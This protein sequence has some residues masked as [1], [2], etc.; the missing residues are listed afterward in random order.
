MGSAYP[1]A[2]LGPLPVV[3]SNQVVDDPSQTPS[4]VVLSNQC[5]SAMRY[6]PHYSDVALFPDLVFVW[7]D[8]HVDHGLQRIALNVL[9]DQ[10][11]V[12]MAVV[13]DDFL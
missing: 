13:I 8:I 3:L 9:H 5:F 10:I 6:P 4:P 7:Y 11:I 2:R 12:F 1:H